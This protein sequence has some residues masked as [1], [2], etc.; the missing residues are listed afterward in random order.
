MGEDPGVVAHNAARDHLVEMYELL[1]R[2]H[3]GE[4]VDW[5]ES[6]ALAGFDGCE[7]CVVREVLNAGLASLLG[8][9]A[10]ETKEES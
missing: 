3:D 6:G 4:D 8:Q 9:G 1:D 5:A 10:I 2:E 7:D